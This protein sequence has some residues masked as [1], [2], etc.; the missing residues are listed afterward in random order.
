MKQWLSSLLLAVL[1]GMASSS[2][3]N[4]TF[5]AYYWILYALGAVILNDVGAHWFGLGFGRT[6]LIALSPKKTVE[7]FLGGALFSYL[8]ISA[9]SY[10]F[11]TTMMVVCP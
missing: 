9:I 3:L 4:A 6:P 1:F 7:G 5:L 2:Y 10:Y 11:S 8:W